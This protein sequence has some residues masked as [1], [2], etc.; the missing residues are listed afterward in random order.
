MAGQSSFPKT[1]P[2]DGRNL[3][4]GGAVHIFEAPGIFRR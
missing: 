1:R 2:F 4:T 3:I